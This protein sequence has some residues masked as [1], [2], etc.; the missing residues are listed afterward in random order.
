MHLLE[1]GLRDPFTRIKNLDPD[2][3]VLLVEIEHGPRLH[4]LRLNF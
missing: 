1:A 4:F 2:H 3:L